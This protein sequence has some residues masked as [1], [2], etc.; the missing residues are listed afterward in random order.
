MKPTEN[1]YV[2]LVLAQNQNKVKYEFSEEDTS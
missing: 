1:R 2:I